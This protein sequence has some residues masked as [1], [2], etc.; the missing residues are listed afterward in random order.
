MFLKD[1]SDRMA[2]QSNSRLS[3]AD[4]IC[5]ARNLGQFQDVQQR[6][7]I[8]SIGVSSTPLYH[9]AARSRMNITHTRGLGEEVRSSN[10]LLFVAACPT[11]K[12]LRERGKDHQLLCDSFIY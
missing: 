7:E 9:F 3:R 8:I 5:P 6:T 11:A 4:L 10:L 12:S 2:R 1:S